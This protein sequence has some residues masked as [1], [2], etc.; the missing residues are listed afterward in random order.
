MINNDAWAGSNPSQIDP[1]ISELTLSTRKIFDIVRNDKHYTVGR[2]GYLRFLKVILKS[3][4]Q[5]PFNN[6]FSY[7]EID[8]LFIRIY[9]KIAHPYGITLSV[10]QIGCDC[11]ISQNTNI[12][13][14]IKFQ[15]FDQSTTGFKPRLGFC[16]RVNP[17]ALISGPIT[18]GSFSIIAGNSIVTKDVPPL[19]IVYG[20]NEIKPIADHHYMTFMHILHQQFIIAGRGTTGILWRNGSYLFCEN[21][22]KIQNFFVENY[23]HASLDNIKTMI[24]EACCSF[25]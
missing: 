5:N 2:G 6:T 12:G 10:D 21:Y 16:I 4:Y 19:S 7:S 17:G 25:R 1:L 14:N 23:G 24:R 8:P 11:V 22:R 18:I 3:R 15:A 13:T 20:R 9:L